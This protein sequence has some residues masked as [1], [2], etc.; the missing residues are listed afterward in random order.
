MSCSYAAPGSRKKMNT[1]NSAT[2]SPDDMQNRI[3]RL[4]G[5]VLSLMTNGAQ[6]AGPT[7]AARALSLSTTSDSQE[8]SFNTADQEDDMVKDEDEE[9][10]SD[11]DQVAKSL[12]ILKVDSNRST[13][14]GEAHWASVLS[15]VGGIQSIHES[16]KLSFTRFRK[17]GIGS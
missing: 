6:S 16:T 5:L 3:D 15:D 14:V 17:S 13:Y 10:E 8:Y 4:E 11:T 12:G 2:T 7:A 1:P 9:V